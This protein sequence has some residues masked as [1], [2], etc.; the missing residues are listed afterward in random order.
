[1]LA[2]DARRIG[3]LSTRG[4]IHRKTRGSDQKR[5][6]PLTRGAMPCQVEAYASS[7]G[8]AQESSDSGENQSENH[9]IGAWRKSRETFPPN[10]CR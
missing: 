10:R 9:K 5:P 6:P 8:A 3:D 4:Q 1:M 2:Q 7:R